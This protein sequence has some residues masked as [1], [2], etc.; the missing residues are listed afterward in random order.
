MKNQWKQWKQKIS[1]AGR[2]ELLLRAVAAGFVLSVLFYLLP[3]VFS[4][5]AISQEVLRLHVIANS[6]SDADQTLKYQVRDAVLTEAA[7]WYGDAQSFEEANTAVC[8]HLQSIAAAAQKVVAENGGSQK[9]CA[10]VT[11]MYFNTRDYDTFSLPAGKY[12][13]LRITL[14]KGEGKNWWCM[15]YPALCLPAAEKQ[16]TDAD[17]LQRLPHNESEIIANPGEYQVQFKIVEWYEA[18]KKMF[19]C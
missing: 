15:V 17:I 3:F 14:G 2:G 5:D 12:R 4:C 9:V 11:D 19:D 6:D 7:K 10:E 8:T 1:R 18:L 13:T 16:E